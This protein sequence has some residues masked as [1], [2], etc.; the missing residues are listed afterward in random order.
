MLQKLLKNAPRAK[1]QKLLNAAR[2][3]LQ[4]LLSP[5]RHKPPAKPAVG[6]EFQPPAMALEDE[7][8]PKS[9]RW[10][11]YV[12]SAFILI[13]V[14]WASL[15]HVDQIVMARG[16]LVTIVPTLVVQ[17]LERVGIKAVHVK[18]GDVVRKGQLLASL[19]PTFTQADVEQLQTKLSGYLARQARLEAE[20]A[21]T[22]FTI[23]A[24]PGQAEILE[25]SLFNERKLTYASRM[26]A[27]DEDLARINSS[28]LSTQSDL[29]KVTARVDLLQK[30]LAMRHALQA[31]DSQLRVFEAQAQLLAAERDLIQADGKI[32]ELRH[33]AASTS[34][35]RDS[36]AQ[37]WREKVA[38][39]LVSVRRDR[40]AAAEE[41]GKAQRRRDMITLSA[42]E[43]AVVLEIA[44]RS[45]GSVLREA[46][47][48]FTLVPLN[49]P[50]EAEVRLSPR[51]IG[52]VHVENDVRI[53]FDAFPFQ[54][55]GTARGKIATI[56]PDA[57][58]PTRSDGS[59]AEP[60]KEDSSTQFHKARVTLQ[61]MKLRNTPEN[62]RLL[63]GMT[64]SAEIKVGT[65]RVISYML[66]PIIKGLDE[67]MREP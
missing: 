11:L 58:R 39:E 17:P 65:R 60:P 50:L 25:A 64:V 54:R 24:S 49:V 23:P 18:V 48:L 20:M 46:E 41:L 51:D 4:R 10:M 47:I 43:D 16:E 61:D 6:R 7:E 26:R 29:E 42:P 67:S 40:G 19:D 8:P 34:A 14:M 9:A 38:D 30:I 63:P 44:Q 5:A 33:Q 15:A 56:S 21:N 31:Y 59:S 3:R 37:E 35:Q 12:L 36:Y 13:I 27:Y 57:F 52:L 55:H 2:E 1:P 53:K 32:T 22:N 28:L 66:Y 62:Y 45:I